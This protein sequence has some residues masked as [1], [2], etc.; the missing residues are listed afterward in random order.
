MSKVAGEGES[1]RA[2]ALPTGNGKKR[3]TSSNTFGSRSRNLSEPTRCPSTA[4]VRPLSH[5][6]LH[7]PTS[8]LSGRRGTI[9]VGSMGVG[10]PH[11]L[12]APVG[13]TGSGRVPYQSVRLCNWAMGEL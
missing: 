2:G 3:H 13:G 8:H 12:A 1:M 5:P 6:Y 7:L 9:P 11:R 10:E 4:S